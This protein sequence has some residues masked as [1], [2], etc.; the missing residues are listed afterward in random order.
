[1]SGRDTLKNLE[2]KGQ[3]LFHGSGDPGLQFLEPR[4]AYNYTSGKQIPDDKPAVHASP[5]IDVAI[6]MAMMN[7]NNFPQEYDTSVGNYG[8]KILF[9]MSQSTSDQLKRLSDEASG[10]VYVFNKENFTP[11]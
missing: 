7:K 2:L 8:G 10:Y 11:R 1:M 4:Q 3:Y 9:A 5:I 6:F